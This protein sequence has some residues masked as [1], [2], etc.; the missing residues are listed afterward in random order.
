MESSKSN[1]WQSSLKKKIKKNMYFSTNYFETLS[2]NSTKFTPSHDTLKISINDPTVIRNVANINSLLLPIF[3]K[4]FANFTY[5]CS[6]LSELIG[7][8]NFYCKSSTNRLKIMT[9][10]PNAYRTLVYF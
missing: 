1:G 5:L 6:E 4:G 8:K 9:T 10:N 3:I 7:I 2:H